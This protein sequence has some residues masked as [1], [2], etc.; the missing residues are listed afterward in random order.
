MTQ[1]GIP[2]PRK[3]EQLSVSGNAAPYGCC[4]VFDLCGDDDLISLTL[5]NFNPFLDWIGWEL[6][7]V[8][9][10]E[11]DFVDR[12]LPSEETRQGWVAD[13]CD[14]PNSVNWG[15]CSFRIEDFARLRRAA[16]V[17]DVTKNHLRLCERQPRYRLD[18]TRIMD[19]LEFNLIL[20]NEVMLQDLMLMV[21]EGNAST[22]GQFDGLEQLVTTGYTD[23]KGRRCSSMDSIVVDWN[24]NG[25]EG[26]AGATWTDARG[27]RSVPTTATITDVIRDGVRIIKS[28]IKNSGLGTSSLQTGDMAVVCTSEMAQAVLDQYT[29]WSVCEGGQFNEAN[30]NTLEARAFRNNL[31]G[32]SITANGNTITVEGFIKIL[33]MDIPVLSYD[34]GLTDG[35]TS[36]IYLLTHKVGQRKV[37]VGQW[38]DMSQVPVRYQNAYKFFSTD[39]GKTLNWFENDHTCVEP[40][41]ETQ[42]RLVSDAPWTNMRITSVT[43]NTVGGAI[44]YDPLN[45]SFFAGGSSFSTAACP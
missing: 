25:L 43:A 45:T 17:Q 15:A 7:D 14:D 31:S 37:L 6:S 9:I 38:N 33:G 11:R 4:G 36:D 32:G 34:W 28:R 20:N 42:P 2:F 16:P 22:A 44:T 19:D 29:C 18:G 21:V 27:V 13:P 26:G 24:A 40:V 35:T 39:G 30:L 23:Y 12:Y 10:I 5:A 3:V 1:R 8:C 41:S